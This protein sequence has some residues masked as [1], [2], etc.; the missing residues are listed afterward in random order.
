MS[1]YQHSN[2]NS[3][4]IITKNALAQKQMTEYINIRKHNI[5]SSPNLIILICLI[6]IYQL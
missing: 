1:D 6:N 5:G 2:D 4:I 3:V